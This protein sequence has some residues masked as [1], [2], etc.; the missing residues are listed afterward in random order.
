[1]A[2]LALTGA[3]KVLSILPKFLLKRYYTRS[4]LDR[5]VEIDVRTQNALMFILGSFMPMAHAFF[6]VRNLTNL[7]W[8]VHEFS[9][10]IHAS[11]QSL[12]MTEFYDRPAEIKRKGKLEILAKCFLNELQVARLKE[13]KTQPDGFQI[14]T[15]YVRAQ[16]ESKIGLVEF[17]PTIEDRHMTIVV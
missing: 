7:T 2:E 11:G 15:I 3:D 6:T 14:A 17:N 10:E 9:A 13:L 5:E 12:M 16:F 8:K 1:L 4:R